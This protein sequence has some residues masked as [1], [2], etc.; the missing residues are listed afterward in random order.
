MVI[1]IFVA[2]GLSTLLFIAAFEDMRERRIP[3]GIT[4]AIAALWPLHV[5]TA[6]VPVAWAASVGI[7]AI[8]FVFGF[9]LFHF[10]L[11]GGGDVKL[12]AAMTLWAGPDL[13][14]PFLLLVTL[15][16]GVLALAMLLWRSTPLAHLATWTRAAIGSLTAAWRPAGV[17][18]PAATTSA[19]H[20]RTLPY[21][22]AIA[23]GSLVVVARL[24]GV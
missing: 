9:V 22:V 10:R 3:N 24:L 11:L 18:A 1:T 15:A 17:S 2:A 14:V 5:V 16:G 6:P 13:A 21:G 23:V 8:V 20:M 19:D 7:A 4:L 12:T